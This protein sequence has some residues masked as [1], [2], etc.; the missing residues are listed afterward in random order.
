MLFIQGCPTAE[1]K[2]I[3]IIVVHLINTAARGVMVNTAIAVGILDSLVPITAD[4][5]TQANFL[6][7]LCHPCWHENSLSTVHESYS[8]SIQCLKL[9]NKAGGLVDLRTQVLT[10][11]K[12]FVL[13]CG[14]ILVY[15]GTYKLTCGYKHRSYT[16]RF[17]C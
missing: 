7:L 15:I 6:L 3:I 11:L 2:S 8:I 9:L 16:S 1:L 12:Q 14:W 10:K 5:H 13:C 4:W 17:A